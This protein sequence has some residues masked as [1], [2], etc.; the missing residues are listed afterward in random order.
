[1]N[2]RFYTGCIVRRLFLAIYIVAS[3]GTWIYAAVCTWQ[4]CGLLAILPFTPWYQV[5]DAQLG[6]DLPGVMMPIFFVLN[7]GIVYGAGKGVDILFSL[8]SKKI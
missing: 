2:N 4:W 1:M 3:V 8:L 5:L 7:C 6:I